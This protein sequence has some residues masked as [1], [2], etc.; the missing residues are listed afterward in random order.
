VTV[1]EPI[2][3]IL[4]ILICTQE[5]ATAA[6]DGYAAGNKELDRWCHAEIVTSSAGYSQR[7]RGGI[8]LWLGT[9]QLDRLTCR[10]ID[11]PY[12]LGLLERHMG[13]SRE[14]KLLAPEPSNLAIRNEK[15]E[16]H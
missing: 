5:Q 15:T 11:R 12:W 10:T 6:D 4:P 3:T 9:G 7:E 13:I 16:R 2:K 14:P 8:A 1:F